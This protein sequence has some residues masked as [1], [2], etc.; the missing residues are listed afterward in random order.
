MR[1]GAKG[2]RTLLVAT[3]ALGTVKEYNQITSNLERPPMG[4]HSC[5][6]KPGPGS[7]FTEDEFAVYK[8]EQQKLEYLVEFRLQHDAKVQAYNALS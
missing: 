8:P 3:V 7:E 2:T 5:H 6:G 1:G 4:F